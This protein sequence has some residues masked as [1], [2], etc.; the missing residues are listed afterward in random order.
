MLK[1][2]VPALVLSTLPCTAATPH[3]DPL[4]AP[5]P[6]L[7]QAPAALAPCLGPAAPGPPADTVAIGGGGWWGERKKRFQ[8]VAV[9]ALSSANVTYLLLTGISGPGAVIGFSVSLLGVLVCL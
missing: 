9:C 2:L 1:T 8:E 3:P 7:V 5:A 4:P 6:L